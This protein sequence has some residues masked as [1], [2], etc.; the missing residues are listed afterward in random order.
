MTGADALDR[1]RE[2]FDHQAWSEVYAQLRSADQSRP[3]LAIDLERLATAAH[4]LGHDTESADLWT[5]A[6]HLLV[7]EG[8]LERAARCAFWVAFYLLFTGEQ[9]QSGGWISRA[10][11][12]LDEGQRD[13]VEQGYLLLP[14]ALRCMF[15]GNITEGYELFSQ[16]VAIGERFSGHDL[17]TLA[18]QGQGRALMRKGEVTRGIALL[19]EVMVAVVGG[20]V[21][22]LLAGTI[23]C[24]VI[25]GCREVYDLRRA[26]EWTAALAH[27]CDSAPEMVPY[28]GQCLVHRAEIMQLHGTWD[29]AMAEA[30]RA[31]EWLSRP[32]GKSG[33]RTAFYQQAELYR[34]RGEFDK[35]EETYRRVSQLGGKPEPGL[36][37][38][39]L[40][41]RQVGAAKASICRALD[42][43]RDGSIRSGLLGPAVEILLAAH[44][45]PAARAAA[46][47]LARIAI[48]LDSL[49]LRAVSDRSTGA[50]LLAEGQPRQALSVL[51][52]AGE[53]WRE[54][55]APYEAA[56][57][58]VLMGVACRALGDN[59]TADMERDAAREAFE[60]LGARV[61]LG[62]LEDLQGLP[63]TESPA[64]LTARE[65]QVLRLVATGKANRIIADELQISEKTVARHI[66]NVFTK[67][68]LSSRSAATAY[69]YQH[70][71]V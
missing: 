11:R 49:F 41:Q 24:S 43:A 36:A 45:V 68:G 60:E 48:R 58:R 28:R 54:I 15:E 37:L 12:L 46:D 6:H 63:A 31:R 44:D 8:Q 25:E 2:A 53:E 13:C 16:A 56:R 9:A 50:V 42:E 26:Q 3:L 22:P 51:R 71:I 59:D 34:L 47:E 21:S 14:D 39:R 29:L 66:S 61:D 35:A 30:E 5:R 38:L 52:R 19:D 23:Y 10:R 57:V 20:E 62:R 64:R 27:W 7:A 4:L 69:A 67:L 18:R 17:V 70:G 32:P 65:V 1:G 55:G 33:A 40:A